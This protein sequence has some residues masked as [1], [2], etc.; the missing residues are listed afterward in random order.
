MQAAGV[1]FSLDSRDP[2]QP[3]AVRRAALRRYQQR[4]ATAAQQP[5]AS[6]LRHYFVV[7][8]PSCLEDGGYGRPAY[9]EAVR[10]RHCRLALTE[11]CSHGTVHGGVSATC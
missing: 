1:E 8:R 2:P 3:E 4:V 10:E 11:L 9:I 5:R 6:Q 7:V